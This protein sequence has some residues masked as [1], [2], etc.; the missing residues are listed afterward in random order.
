MPE[1]ELRAR[2]RSACLL[3]RKVSAD[4]TIPTPQRRARSRAHSDD[5]RFSCPHEATRRFAVGVSGLNHTTRKETS[6]RCSITCDH[7]P[8]R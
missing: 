7:A 1:L 6:T 2:S 8:L 4:G 3:P 5:A